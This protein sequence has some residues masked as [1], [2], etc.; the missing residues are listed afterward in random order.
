MTEQ[1][2]TGTYFPNLLKKKKKLKNKTY[3]NFPEVY[4]FKEPLIQ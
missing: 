2:K 4:I 1:D 3:H